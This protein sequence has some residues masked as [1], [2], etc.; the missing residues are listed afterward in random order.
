ME[1]WRGRGGVGGERGSGLG[2]QSQLVDPLVLHSAAIGIPLW[3][4][5][6]LI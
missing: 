3:F 6:L 1:G 4:V 5:L 2:N